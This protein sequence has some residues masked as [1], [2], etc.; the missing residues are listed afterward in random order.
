MAQT[1]DYELGVSNINQR[2]VESVDG[3][4]IGLMRLILAASALLIIY[5]DPSEPDKLVGLTY[6]ALVIYTI[7]CAVLYYLALRRSSLVPIHV[8]YWMD[9]GWYTL[10][11]SLSSGTSSI[12][13][14]FY[15]FAILVAGFGH[16]FKAGLP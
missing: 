14:F 13:F 7:Y 15:F 10:L 9:I 12:F 8:A 16:G 4:M 5:L 3:N 2:Q 11:I 6:S 1:L